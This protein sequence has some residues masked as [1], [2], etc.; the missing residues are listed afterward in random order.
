MS[1]FGLLGL[2]IA[3]AGV[4]VSV[5][6]LCASEVCTRIKKQPLSQT[7][8]WAGHIATF[9][10]CIALT[11]CCGLL[12][13][14]FMTGDYT[15]EYVLKEHSSTDGFLGWLY[16][17][18]GLWAG[19][20]GSLLFWAWL[21][22]VFNSTIAA[23]NLKNC[24]RLDNMAIAI[25]QLVLFAFVCLL[26]FSSDNMPFAA[27]SSK[28]YTSNGLLTSAASTLGLN[29]LLEHWAM[30][31]HPPTLFIGYAGLTVPFAYAIAALI[32]NDATSTWV[33]RASTYTLFSWLFLSIGIALGSVWAYIVLGWGGYWGWD[34]VENASLF[35]W[36]VGLALIHSFTVYKQRGAFKRWS[37]MC[38]CLTFLFVIIGTFITRSGIV[39]SV[40]AFSGDAT[41]MIFFS[42]LMAF[43]VLAGVVGLAVRWK[44]FG[45]AANGTD[46][47]ENMLSKEGA[48]YFNNVILIA[49]TI[50]LAY[51]TVSSALPGFL[52][53]GGQTVSTGTYN[54][55]ARP[56][57]I[58]YLLILAVC[59]LLAWGKTQRGNF[60]KNAKVPAICACVLF[61]ALAAF[62]AL[63]LLP[64]YNSIIEAGTTEASELASEGPTWYYNGLS[65]VGFLVASLLFFN[66]L[67]MLGR[68]IGATKQKLNS[69]AVKAFFATITKQPARFGGFLAH[70]AMAIILV[71]L[72]GSSMYVTEQ[73]AYIPYDEDSDTA[74]ADIQ[75]KDYTLKFVSSSVEEVSSNKNVIYTVV[76]D[77]Y[78]GDAYIGQVSPSVQVATSTQQQKLNASVIS[79][80]NEDLFVSYRGVSDNDELSMDVRLNP[81]ISFVWV[82]SA[83][84]LLAICAATFGRFA[85]KKNSS[86]P[87]TGV[88]ES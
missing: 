34:A 15:I 52:P 71:G 59:P 72:I 18:S 23:R 58:V 60:L 28:Y 61:I 87:E 33:K 22:S 83:I 55:I 85:R 25:S 29:P 20:E 53:F 19:K 68:T 45:P 16:K 48:Y 43:A 44:N 47:I 2:L 57:G 42:L 84:L 49:F 4:S 6:C 36:L 27:T 88:H 7:L 30:A 75:I 12:V 82:G 8:N 32:V 54:A 66:A 69:G 35:S 64:S 11:F 9:T 63:N 67:F 62:W 26:L 86:S 5:L 56:L 24:E 41:S 3:F 37:I 31:I 10:T 14:C 38:A 70:T 51:L 39:Q 79:L 73:T 13:Y 40:H 81:L 21:I 50:L 17:L 46:N 65:L 1:T 78:K 80:P 76:F 77:A 74:S